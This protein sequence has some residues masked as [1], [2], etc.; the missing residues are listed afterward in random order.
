MFK[1]NE[2]SK[3]AKYLRNGT[4]PKI[5]KTEDQSAEKLKIDFRLFM[6]S[7]SEQ[8]NI[9]VNGEVKKISD[10]SSLITELKE[11]IIYVDIKI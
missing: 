10:V 11:K 9:L 2:L 4:F 8:A 3:Y 6:D 1:D 7:K 5:V